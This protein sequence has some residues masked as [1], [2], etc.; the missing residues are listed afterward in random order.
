MS[1]PH[2]V[3]Y[4]GD[5]LGDWLRATK[6]QAGTD[7]P[8][9]L[10][11]YC[12]APV[13]A[14]EIESHQSPPD[15]LI[16][17]VL[18]AEQLA[19]CGGRY[20]TLKTS[21]MAAA[22]VAMVLG[23]PFLGRFPVP[24]PRPVV[25]ISGESGS[26]TTIETVRRICEFHGLGVRDVIDRGLHLSFE[27]PNFASEK[28][29]TAL[30]HDLVRLKPKP[31]VLI[32][33]P[34]YACMGRAASQPTSLF[35][36]GRAYLRIAETCLEAGCT[37]ILT[38]HFKTGE[39]G[40]IGK[41]DLS[42]LLYAGIRE[43]SRQ[44]ILL[45]RREPFR[46]GVGVHRLWMAAG[47]SVG[48]GGIWGVDLDEGIQGSDFTGRRW[49]VRVMEEAEAEAADLTRKQSERQ[50]RRQTREEA[51]QLAEDELLLRRLAE[52]DPA[53]EGVTR[54]ALGAAVKW[55]WERVNL[56]LD[57]LADTSV[58]VFSKTTTSGKGRK[59]QAEYIRRRRS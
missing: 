38:H 42:E 3:D 29:R 50:Q 6:E 13:K 24:K 1:Y 47:G 33:D 52:I 2:E 23:K 31:E 44:W 19:V 49:E 16:E 57:R 26:F 18:V 36:M 17:R 12:L 48:H 11:S 59:Q 15:W 56:V 54:R 27:L 58:E 7:R 20:K 37:P 30:Q 40:Q 34:A 8:E 41:P 32:V 10:N 14:N 4:P 45:G 35:A 5:K 25:L 51:K 55:G 9:F 43:A 46:P 39:P 22:A 28:Q 53:N 21:C